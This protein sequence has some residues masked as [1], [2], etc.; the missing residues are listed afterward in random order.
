MGAITEPASQRG[1][2]GCWIS[3]QTRRH[4]TEG[5]PA[6]GTRVSPARAPTQ[7]ARGAGVR[8]RPRPGPHPQGCDHGE[9][10]LPRPPVH[11]RARERRL[12]GLTPARAGRDRRGARTLPR[13]P[14][15]EGGA[16]AGWS[17]VTGS[18]NQAVPEGS[19]GQ[20]TLSREQ[21]GREAR[22]GRRRPSW[23][24]QMSRSPRYRA[25]RPHATGTFLPFVCPKGSPS[26][27]SHRPSLR[28]QQPRR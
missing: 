28:W 15:P 8:P 16:L 12:G 25:F 13:L 20:R 17:D 24:Q 22:L 26:S 3:A 4:Q 21:E 1:R 19:P 6:V 27:H 18:G 11:P 9:E 23:F 5:P 7:E 10:Q 2:R 14:G